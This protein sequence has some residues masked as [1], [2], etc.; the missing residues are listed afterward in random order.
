MSFL[1]SMEAALQIPALLKG[2]SFTDTRGT[3]TFNNDFDASAIK[4]VYTLQNSSLDFKRGWQGHKIEQRWL[5]AIKGGFTI[6]VKP[7]YAFET[8]DA[9]APEYSFTLTD[10]TLDYLHVPPGYVTCIQAIQEDSKMLL[11]SDYGIGEVQD[12]WRFDL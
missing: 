5:A 7:I 6:I 2:K 10:E 8:V 3:L 9:N 12:E 4:R 11:L 1:F